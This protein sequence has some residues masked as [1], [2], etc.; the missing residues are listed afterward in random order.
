MAV[1][2]DCEGAPESLDILQVAASKDVYAIDCL[3]IGARKARSRLR[4]FFQA[5]S[6]IK[7]M[8]DLRHDAIALSRHGGAKLL[9]GALDAQLAAEHIW[10]KLH[11]GLNVL[12]KRLGKRGRDG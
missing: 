3:Q 12:M 1:A 6:V 9:A 10:G 11:L 4:K 5:A 7:L 2:V 8:H